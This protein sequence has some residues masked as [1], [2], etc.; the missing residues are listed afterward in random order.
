MN[1]IKPNDLDKFLEEHHFSITDVYE[2]DKTDLRKI[3]SDRF[4]ANG[5]WPGGH[6]MPISQL[7]YDSDDC[8]RLIL[9]DNGKAIGF[10]KVYRLTEDWFYTSA[11]MLAKEY[12]GHG[13][14]N[15]LL[16]FIARQ[17]NSNDKWLSRSAVEG[18]REKYH[19]KIG[20]RLGLSSNGFSM[21]YQRNINKILS[22]PIPD[23]EIDTDFDIHDLDTVDE[24][25]ADH[26][27]S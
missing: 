20:D 11:E 19:D 8:H 2:S 23:Y 21:K 25:T 12:R 1:D 9:R 24:D 26:F 15:I 18:N 3:A 4:V 13:Y 5:F 27:F 22:Q 10:I 6:V 14:Y 7:I 17:F 16:N